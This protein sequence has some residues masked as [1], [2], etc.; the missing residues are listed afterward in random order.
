MPVVRKSSVRAALAV[1]PMALA[2]VLGSA[3]LA[4]ATEEDGRATIHEGNLDR[5]HEDACTDL[6]GQPLPESGF[7][8][9]G[10]VG[11][12]YLTINS[13]VDGTTVT[14]IVVKGGPAYNVYE[15]GAGLKEALEWENL[16]SPLME[17]KNGGHI[18]PEI[19]HWFAC[20]V[21][22]GKTTSSE[23]PTKSK[24]EQPTKSSESTQPK[25]SS[26]TPT[27]STP[28]TPGES[29]SVPSTTSTVGGSVT[30]TTT[31]GAIA[32]ENASDS[33]D[34]ASTGFGSSWL[35]WAGGLLVLAGAAVL[36]LLRIRRNA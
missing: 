9:T 1:V 21:P 18:I 13:V 10:G 14:G 11:H 8:F 17:K 15:P 5:E 20:G 2:V 31:L 7:T 6:G 24:P 19:S 33:D 4:H 35:L 16:Q 3:G 25:T 29:S 34:L 28:E 27:E 30:T 23:A 32:V 22:T 12:Q 26:S 36:V